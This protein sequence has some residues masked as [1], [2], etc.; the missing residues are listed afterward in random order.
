MSLSYHTLSNTVI[1]SS[2]T[3][4]FC[5]RTSL[6]IYKSVLGTFYFTKVSSGNSLT[7]CISLDSTENPFFWP[8]VAILS[9][10]FQV[11]STTCIKA[12]AMCFQL[13]LLHKLF[14][15]PFMF[16]LNS[17]EQPRLNLLSGLWQS[18]K[19]GSR[20]IQIIYQTSTDKVS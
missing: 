5:L 19:K 6:F 16:P 18:S 13:W 1:E 7:D 9:V 14:L 12:M 4:T 8:P 15:F 10:L 2:D 11:L 20:I 3:F 17:L